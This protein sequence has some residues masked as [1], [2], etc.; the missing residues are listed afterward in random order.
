MDIV[1]YTN[2]ET[3]AHKQQEGIFYW[4]ITRPPR[5]LKAGDRIFF[6]IKGHIIGSFKCKEFN[7]ETD[8]YGD[9][10]DYETIVWDS[11]SWIP[12]KKPIPTKQF[13][14]FKYRNW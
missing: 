12:L 5:N 1:I 9:P 6:A 10:I 4:E 14:G 8:E 2:P 13:Q 7:L 3:L 11:S